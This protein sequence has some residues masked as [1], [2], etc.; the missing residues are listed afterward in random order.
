MP[1]LMWEF[2]IFPREKCPGVTSIRSRQFSVLVIFF[3]RDL[4]LNHTQG[5][6]KFYLIVQGTPLN[7]FNFLQQRLPK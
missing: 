2:S 3:G 5:P 7:H 6:E 4:S 1:L